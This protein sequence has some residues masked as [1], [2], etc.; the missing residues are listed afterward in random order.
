LVD[1]IRREFEIANKKLVVETGKVA[2]QADGAVTL[3]MGGTVVLATVVASNEPREGIDFVPLTVDVVERMYAAGK[4]PGGFI[5]R[6]GRPSEKAI[7]NARLIDRPLRPNFPK[8]FNHEIH[9]MVTILSVDQIH[10][11]DI[12]AVNSASYA[13]M[14]SSIPFN[15]PIG[16]VQV[17]RLNGKW[18]VNPTL[19]ELVNSDINLKVAGTKEAIV[20]VEAGSN[21]VS[22]NDIV[23]AI[24]VAHEQIKEIVEQQQQFC[25]SAG[26]EKMEFS[27]EKIPSELEEK[28][29][30]L[31]VDELKAAVKQADKTVRDRLISKITEDVLATLEEESPE[32]LE[33]NRKLVKN[34]L[35][36]IE[37]EIVRQMILKEGV[38]VDGRKPDEIR[39]LS[40]EAG[41]LPRTHGSGL[42][43]RG[44]TQ[45]LSVV[46]L[47]TMREEQMIDGLG[48]EESKRFI[49]HY[50]F[51]PFSV[52][53]PGRLGIPK[54]REVGHGALAE[55][56]LLP[57]IPDEDKFP[58]AIRIVSDVL[59]SNGSTSMASVCASS[60]ALM[61]AGI[62]V[63]AAV[64]GVAMGLVKEG[65]SVAVLTDIQGLEDALGDMDFKVAGTSK[66]VTALQMDIKVPSVD[67]QILREALTQARR[68]RMIILDKMAEAIS[69]PR[70]ELSPYA[71]RIIQLKV[72]VDKIREIIGPGGK[73]IQGIIAETGTTI[74]IEDDGT[75]YVASKDVAGG[76]RAKNMIEAIIK[77]VEP[78]DIFVGRVTKTMPFGAFVELK[79]GREGLVHISKLAKKRI[80]KVEDIVHEGD[81]I[82]VRV[83]EIDQ[84]NRVSLTAID[85]DPEKKVSIQ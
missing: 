14:I 29:R 3:Q 19:Q 41:L 6:E 58:Y 85:V 9:I 31:A 1:I 83:L 30:H 27:V 18:L 77:E 24:E 53:E 59:E 33:G 10:P 67:S 79:P 73:V 64:G 45:V 56:A 70:K 5:K 50:N 23:E 34:L 37:K 61:D 42:F 74:D 65:D 52:G 25:L 40:T 13:L 57:T 62:P 17:G 54:R 2:R 49:H 47:G 84:Q 78:G 43:T 38:R 69:A 15:G 8:G 81:R 32:E 22:E 76:K 21:E 4:I 68:A 36:E 48:I 11:P 82:A 16:A 55:K 20:M 46:T 80:G 71:P 7:L 75:V 35:K 60:M 39:S 63:S 51:P 66:G 12:L 44:Q 72:P 28:V 26:K